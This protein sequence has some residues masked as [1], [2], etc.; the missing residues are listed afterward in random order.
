[1][2]T[3]APALRY[4]QSSLEKTALPDIIYRTSSTTSGRTTITLLPLSDL[5]RALPICQELC[6][7]SSSWINSFDLPNNT[8][9]E[10]LMYSFYK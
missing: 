1:M 7:R 6:L 8:S 5:N 9:T 3:T 2:N 10:M 4:S